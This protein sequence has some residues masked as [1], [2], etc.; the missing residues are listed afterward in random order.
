MDDDKNNFD[1]TN[2][3]PEVETFRANYRNFKDL[4]NFEVNINYS[5]KNN[6]SVSSLTDK[7]SNYC[8]FVDKAVIVKQGIKTND[9]FVRSVS[10][11][12]NKNGELTDIFIYDA[13]SKKF[14]CSF[15][16]SN[17]EFLEKITRFEVKDVDFDLESEPVAF[18]KGKFENKG[19]GD[20]TYLS[21]KA[22]LEYA[23]KN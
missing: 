7:G 9:R 14:H 15:A 13:F 18:F 8:V 21:S 22:F 3:F 20:P 10:H 19:K 1:T 11:K 5:D 6:S 17:S 2:F 4:L 16:V 23:K 12:V